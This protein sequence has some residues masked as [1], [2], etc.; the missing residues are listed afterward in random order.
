MAVRQVPLLV[1]AGPCLHC[2]LSANATFFG[3]IGLGANP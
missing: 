2:M 3:V 1:F